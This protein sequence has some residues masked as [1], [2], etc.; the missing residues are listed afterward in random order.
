VG[1]LRGYIKELIDSVGRTCTPRACPN[2]FSLRIILSA[3]YPD[4]ESNS[5]DK[6]I[7]I[8]EVSNKKNEPKD[9]KFTP[10]QVYLYLPRGRKMSETIPKQR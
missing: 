5:E 1:L 3:T 7:L 9:H 4:F 2:L 8:Q 6:I 10:S